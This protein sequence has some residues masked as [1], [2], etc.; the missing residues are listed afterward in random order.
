MSFPNFKFKNLKTGSEGNL[1]DLCKNKKMVIDF[2]H[3]KCSKCPVALE[4]LN[5]MANQRKSEENIVFVA[6]ALSLGDGNE[7]I[8]TDMIDEWEDLNHIFVSFEV[9]EELKLLLNFSALP[10]AAIVSEVNF[11]LSFCEFIFEF[12]R[13]GWYSSVQW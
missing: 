4:K 12:D 6:C 8:V 1:G 9:K 13:P 11:S 5:S 7:E 3:S 10:F 2:W